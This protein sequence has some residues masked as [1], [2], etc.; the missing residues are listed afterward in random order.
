M[1]DVPLEHYDKKPLERGLRDLDWVS[2]CAFAHQALIAE[3]SRTTT[4]APMQLFTLFANDQRARDHLRRIR[5]RIEKLLDRVAG[6]QEWGVRL[7]FDPKQARQRTAAEQ[8]KRGLPRT[9]R[10]FLAL[11]NAAET[12]RSAAARR[13][14][15][16]REELFTEL[17]RDVAAARR[18]ELAGRKRAAVSCSTPRS[19]SRRREAPDFKRRVSRAAAELRERGIASLLTGPWPAYSFLKEPARAR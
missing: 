9:G 10:G 17:G 19:W 1:S 16:A 5:A 7:R 2:R 14:G 15:R 3:L 8:R 13:R 11:K 6:H 18:R 4:V 12:R